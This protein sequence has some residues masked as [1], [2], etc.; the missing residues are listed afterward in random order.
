MSNEFLDELGLTVQSENWLYKT[1]E[2]KRVQVINTNM[3]NCSDSY[4]IAHIATRPDRYPIHYFHYKYNCG[5]ILEFNNDYEGECHRFNSLVYNLQYF[6]DHTPSYHFAA[7]SS[8]KP[9]ILE[10][11]IMYEDVLRIFTEKFNDLNI[12]HGN[13]AIKCKK[14]EVL[15]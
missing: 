4:F 10:V 8:M 9:L 13:Y 14:L 12:G 5:T 7:R 11:K 2:F 15:N 1:T 6:K 3:F